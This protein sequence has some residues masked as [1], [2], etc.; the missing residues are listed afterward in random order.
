MLLTV[1]DSL[2]DH[3][4][5]ERYLS[6]VRRGVIEDDPVQRRIIPLFDTLCSQL[7]SHGSPLRL[8]ETGFRFFKKTAPIIRNEVKG[9]YLWGAVG[10]GKTML[11]DLFFESLTIPKKRRV[12]FQEFMAEIH[13]R[14]HQWRQASKAGKTPYQEPV[15]P[16]VEDLSREISV[17][18][19]DEFSVTDIADVMI[20][21]RLFSGL[22]QK[23][24]VIVAT[25]N[26]EPSRLYENGLNRALFLPFISELQKRMHIVSL[27]APT[28]YR[29]KKIGSAP[30]FYSPLSEENL[31]AMDHVFLDLTGEK[32]GTRKALTVKGHEFVIPQHVGKTARLSFEDLC[33][34]ALGASDYIAL[35]RHF[36]TVFLDHVPLMTLDRR[37]EAK[38]FILL[39]DALYNAKVKLI[40]SAE[41]EVTN[42][43]NASYGVEKFEF[44]RTISRLIE[45]R[46]KEYLVAAHQPAPVSD[47]NIPD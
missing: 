5:E 28:D 30:V 34:K 11:M 19:F 9:I 42:L 29:L 38:R 1:K 21:G 40:M 7:R 44:E 10:R 27:A 22:F 17:L 35:A 39:I 41:T 37:N 32:K 24:L 45:M 33:G 46:S 6:L 3:N 15:T 18:C 14:V 13:E 8:P 4:V 26:V 2:P 47:I 16:I 12:H 20:L 36:T 43:Y 25:S 23:G 31:R